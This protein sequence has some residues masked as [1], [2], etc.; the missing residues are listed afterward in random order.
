[1][2]LSDVFTASLV[3]PLVAAHGGVH[4][5]PKLFGM[6]RNLKARNPWTGHQNMGHPAG[7][8]LQARQ[9]EGRCG[10]EGGGASCPAGSCCSPA[11]WI[12]RACRPFIL[13]LMLHRDIVVQ[14]PSTAPHL[15][16]R[17]TLA[18]AVMLT[19]PLTELALHKTPVAN[20][21]TLHMAVWEFVSA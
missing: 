15:T 1:M 18:L 7:P 21:E 19:R 13:I 16:A 10:A 8:H 14:P 11:V 4:G 3:V 17:S 9:E 2:R 6:H 12:S 5:A 20:S